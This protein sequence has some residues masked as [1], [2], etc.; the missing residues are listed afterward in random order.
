MGPWWLTWYLCLYICEK[1]EMSRMW[2]TDGRT[3]ARTVESRAVFSLSWIRKNLKWIVYWAIRVKVIC[4]FMVITAQLFGDEIT[5]WP[6]V[7]LLGGEEKA[8]K[9]RPW[10]A[11]VNIIQTFQIKM[12]KRESALC[13]KYFIGQICGIWNFHIF[14][15]KAHCTK[16]QM[17]DFSY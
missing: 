4:H 14:L 15:S 8:C 3:N 16:S 1:C 5:S 17:V 2:R 6:S 7:Y 12:V 13:W 11:L 10:S 9:K